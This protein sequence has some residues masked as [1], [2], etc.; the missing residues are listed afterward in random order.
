MKILALEFS[1]SRRSAAVLSS[2][3]GIPPVSPVTAH[4]IGGRHTRALAL[5]E[6]ALRAAGGER[7]DVECIAVGLGPGSYA[8]IRSAIALAQGWQLARGVKLLGISSVECLA[9]QAQAL[10]WHG[11]IHIALD[12]QRGEFYMA[13]YELSAGERREVE[14]LHLASLAEVQACATD[15]AMLFS[16]DAQRIS[17]TAR[18]LLP[19]AAV[20]AQLAST[21]E[22]FVPGEKLEPIY[23]R[24][25][26]F[27]KA[28][29][30]RVVL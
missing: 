29:L 14:P 23:L 26:S 13:G 30:P 18:E 19:E 10:G 11:R 6:Q 9:A 15:G 4:E 7:E 5:V 24:E 17:T 3:T 12:A 16:P 22:D 8:G 1:S 2:G 27:V 25:S 20:L 28:P 21:R